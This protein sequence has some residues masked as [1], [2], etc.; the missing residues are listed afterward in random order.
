MNPSPLI[1]LS[2]LI[3]ILSCKAPVDIKSESSNLESLAVDGFIT[4]A[5]GP[6]LISLRKTRPFVN[7]DIG[8]FEKIDNASISITDQS[9]NVESLK[10][11]L[12]G[13]Y[14]TRR[15]YQAVIGSTYTLRIEYDEQVFESTPQEVFPPHE[16]LDIYAEKKVKEF[17]INGEIIPQ[18]VVDFYMDYQGSTQQSYGI[19]DW[20]GQFTVDGETFNREGESGFSGATNQMTNTQV[21]ERIGIRQ[22][23]LDERF[24]LQYDLNIALYSVSRSTFEFHSKVLT[25][26]ELDGSVF[27]PSPLQIEGNIFS[28]EDPD[29]IAFGYFGAFSLSYDTASVRGLSIPV[30]ID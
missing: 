17:L 23:L 10:N 2:L 19:Y 22:T 27:D 1:A 11:M 30:S 13:D 16:I 4:T 21:N 20:I 15:E 14:Q 7:D 3:S 28:M 26:R 25:Q 5:L 24:S 6:H 12:N 29:Q 8:I 18:A 9:G